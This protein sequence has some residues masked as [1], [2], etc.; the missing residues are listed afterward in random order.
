M[1]LLSKKIH[2]N[3][4]HRSVLT[5]V[6][7]TASQERHRHRCN[8]PQLTLRARVDCQKQTNV[9]FTIS[10]SVRVISIEAC[11]WRPSQH[12]TCLGECQCFLFIAWPLIDV[13][14]EN[15]CLHFGRKE[16]KE[17]RHWAWLHTQRRFC[18]LLLTLPVDISLSFWTEVQCNIISFATHSRALPCHV[19][20]TC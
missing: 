7:V 3:F 11:D 19:W 5:R 10:F 16:R 17:R 20:W 2:R 8:G 1:C 15:V 13:T 12:F 6:C 18:S 14:T 4:N 9:K